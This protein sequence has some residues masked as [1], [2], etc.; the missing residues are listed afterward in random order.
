MLC[1]HKKK[2]KNTA[3][4]VIAIIVGALAAAAGAYFLFTKV[5]KGKLC[6]KNDCEDAIECDD[7][8]CEETADETCD[9][10]VEADAE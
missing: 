9:V 8:D 3:L 7:C 6:K 4:M 1:F 5:L 10:C 2:K